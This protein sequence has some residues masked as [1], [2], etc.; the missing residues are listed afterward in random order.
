MNSMPCLP[1][2][3][4]KRAFQSNLLE[5]WQWEQAQFDGSNATFECVTRPDSVTLLAFLDADTVLLTDQEQP[6]RPQAFLDIPGGR[7]DPGEEQ[8]AAAKRELLEETGYS[9]DTVVEWSRRTHIG[10]VRFEE[11][12]FV[13]T[14]LTLNG[15]PHLDKGERIK[16]RTVS[17]QELVQLCLEGKLRQPTIMLAILQMEYDPPSRERLQRLLAPLQE[18]NSQQT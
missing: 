10:L 13:G 9:A 14:R 4:A 16:P 12:L 8:S 5:V 3:Y 18:P 7:V 6:H 15:Q 1:P 2:P 17:W 11:V